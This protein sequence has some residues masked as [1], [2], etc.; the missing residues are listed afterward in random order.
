MGPRVLQNDLLLRAAHRQRTERTP[1]WLMRQAGR[2]DPAYRA[3]RERD[4]RP[5]EDLFRDPDIATEISLLPRR[6][7]VDALIS[8]QDIL[9]PLEPFGARFV[10]R[11]GP[12]LPDPPRDAAAL[13][14]LTGSDPADD[15]PFVGQ[16]LRQLRSAVGNALPLLGFAGAPFTLA[17]FL[18]EGAS[19]PPHLPQVRAVWRS[20]PA[21]LHAL[22]ERL[23]DL[24]ADYLRYQA[25]SGADA[26]QLF[27]SLADL[28]SEDE[29]ATWAQPYQTRVFARYAAATPTILFV[30]EQ[31]FVERMV[32]TGAAV[33]SVGRCVDLATAQARW[34]A[35]VAF[36]GNVDNRVVA[37]GTLA[38]IDAAVEACL[39][40][41]GGAGHILNLNHGVL[42]DT[43]FENGCR[44]IE[45]ARRIQTHVAGD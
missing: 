8:Y 16:T 40:A 28:L 27:E 32:A 9:T 10:F 3:I 29:Y 14:R 15:L 13:D 4:P 41:G 31:P 17:A 19:P 23:A 42:K 37:T 33:L 21:A 35:Q 22:L 43:P 2:F 30:K 7:G 5:L 38:E 20:A 1:V 6:F 45:A 18:L 24:T 12:V 25:D 26:V 36:Q 44:V 34:G 39:T 11:P